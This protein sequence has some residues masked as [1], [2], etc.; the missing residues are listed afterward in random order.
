M[1]A[2]AKWE[3]FVGWLKKTPD[4][5][6]SSDGVCPICEKA[7]VFTATNA[8]FRDYLSC[9]S[10]RSVVRERA[11]ALVLNELRPN[12]RGLAIHE[13]SPGGNGI[14]AKL[15][16]EGERYVASHYYPSQPMGT[17]VGAF[18]NE[19]LEAQTFEDAAF[20]I[21]VSLDVMEHLFHPDRAYA[22]IFRTLRP[23]GLYIHTFPIYK[24]QVEA[25]TRFAE[26]ADDGTVTHLVETP[27]YHG[28][29]ID[30]DGALVTFH[31]G[32][33][34]TRQIAQWAPFDVRITRFN[35]RTHGILGEF[36][37][38]VIC[39]KPAAA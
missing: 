6:Y 12:W 18:R 9:P 8:W 22:E 10:C 34:I 11:L 4:P 15:R 21:V 30:K 19:N 24:A 38:V 33:N 5:V 31:Y 36:T 25:A 37:E 17:Q 3:M 32:Y 7:V 35:D 28:N 27:E 39:T 13:S 23:G 16:R 26:L 2:Q 29:P 1:R 20:D 14:S